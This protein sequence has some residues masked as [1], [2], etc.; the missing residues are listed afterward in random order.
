MATFEDEKFKK[1]VVQKRTD[2]YFK[3]LS[4]GIIDFQ[5]EAN[6][7]AKKHS[8]ITANNLKKYMEALNLAH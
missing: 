8:R 6:A 5:K 3:N 7:N 1:R 4:D 2:S